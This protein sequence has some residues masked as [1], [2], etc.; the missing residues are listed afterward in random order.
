MKL[1]HFSVAIAL[2]DRIGRKIIQLVGFMSLTILLVI[3][4]FAY[5][6]IKKTSIGLFVTLFT[7]IQFFFNFGPNITTFIIPG[8][9]FAE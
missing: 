3:F 2:A 4:G 1:I 5:E 8:I 7:L 9:Y 6:P